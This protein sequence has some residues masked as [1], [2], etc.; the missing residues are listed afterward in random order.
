[1]KLAPQ[2]TENVSPPRADAPAHSLCHPDDRPHSLVRLSRRGRSSAW[3]LSYL[4][5]SSRR[6]I[7]DSPHSAS[8][9]CAARSMPD[10][11]PCRLPSRAARQLPDQS[12]ILRV[13]S[14]STD[15]SRLRGARPTRDIRSNSFLRKKLPVYVRTGHFGSTVRF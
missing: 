9:M 2:L 8:P 15:D 13:E 3:P 7:A 11:E 6:S 5:P 12:T 10:L 14:S 1:M 4:A